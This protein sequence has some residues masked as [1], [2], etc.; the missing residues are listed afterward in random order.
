MKQ[1]FNLPLKRV[2]ERQRKCNKNL[3]NNAHK[4]QTKKKKKQV[5]PKQVDRIKQMELGARTHYE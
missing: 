5:K 2:E 4:K 1:N 3:I